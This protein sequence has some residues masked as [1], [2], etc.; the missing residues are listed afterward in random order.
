MRSR[1]YLVGYLGQLFDN[2]FQ[3]C[4][5]PDDNYE[6]TITIEDPPED[7]QSTISM[8]GETRF[9]LEAKAFPDEVPYHSDEVGYYAVGICWGGILFG[10]NM[11]EWDIIW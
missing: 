7:S 9:T 1:V 6:G 5:P 3:E 8:D 11:L 4:E 10:R 2:G